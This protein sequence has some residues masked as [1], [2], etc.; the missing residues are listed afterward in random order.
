MVEIG[1]SSFHS[2][3][4]LACRSGTWNNSQRKKFHEPRNIVQQT[5]TTAM[6]LY[7]S[8]KKKILYGV[9][10]QSDTA[11]ETMTSSYGWQ[12]IADDDEQLVECGEVALL[13]WRECG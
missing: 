9:Q 5:D 13:Q 6:I 8:S 12:G 2:T 11:F 4:I 7:G 10:N 3:T 1:E